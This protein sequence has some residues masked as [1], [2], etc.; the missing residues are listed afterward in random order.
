MRGVLMREVLFNSTGYRTY[1]K[2]IINANGCY[3]FDN[4]GNKYLDLEAGVWTLPLGHCDDDINKAIHQQVDTLIHCGY[5]YSHQIAEGCA[6]KL[7]TI[8]GLKNGKCVFLSS[9]SE[10]VE[11]GV[12]LAKSI[13]SNK[14]CIC[15]ENQYLSAYGSCKQQYEQEW[16]FVEW[17]YR[18]TKS[19]EQF[20]NDLSLAI[21]FSKVGVFVFEPGNSSGL[22]KLPPK[23][24]VT[25]LSLLCAENNV[26]IVVD[27]I[28][29]GVG[30]TGKWFGYMHYEMQPHIIA[31]GKGLGNG[32]P[33]SCVVIEENA[34]IDAQKVNFHYAQSHQ[35]DPLG[36]R[37]AYEV[38]TKIEQ[39][40]LLEKTN[41]VASYFM[42]RYK[43][44]QQKYPIISEIRGIGLLLCIELSVNVSCEAMLDIEKSLFEQGFIVGIKPNERVIRTYCPLIIESKMIDEYI[45]ALKNILHQIHLY[46]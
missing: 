27:E 41:E 5:K 9:G 39:K 23:N 26:I 1:N 30:R 35:N 7:L 34:A 4:C 32:Y 46:S 6:N 38:L 2:N 14:K 21:D 31:V 42:K 18:A 17:D 25:A 20:Y 10:A 45:S 22:V 37:V 13:R 43:E 24:L 36:C 8:T 11:Y 19:V 12:Q 3:V 29:C 16:E 44:L 40:Q 28:T 15:L 33:I